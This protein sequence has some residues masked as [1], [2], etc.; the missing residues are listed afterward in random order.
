MDVQIPK[1]N[2]KRIVVVGGGFG[3]LT[4]INKLDS[5]YFQ[6][7]LVD[8]NNY[9]QF[10]PL[11]YQVASSGLE[12]G[13]ISFPFR[14]HFHKKKN[15]Y[16]RLADVKE[17]DSK[18]NQIK[19]SIGNI[20]YDYLVLA[21]GTTTN[22]FG[23]KEIEEQALPMKTVEEALELKNTLLTNL[24]KALDCSDVE[25]RK[26][27]LN[28][29]I[30]GAGATGVEIAGAL[31]EMRRYIIPKDYPD[32]KKNNLNIYLIEGSNKVLGNLS[33]ESSAN[34]LKALKKMGVNVIL[35]KRVTAYK[36]N[37]VIMDDESFIA[38][39]TLVWVSGVASQHFEGLPDEV[40][41]HAGRLLVNEYNQLQNSSNIFVLGDLCLQYE[42]SYPKGHPQVAPVAIQQGKLLASN[43][44]K[45]EKGE[46]L[47]PFKYFNQGT[48]AT[49][50]RNKAVADIK[51]LRLHGFIAWM[52][53]ML[54][55]LRSILG[56]RNKLTV[57][58]DWIWNYLTYDQSM[59]FI[60]YVKPNK[61]K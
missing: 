54:V 60:I 10:Q 18:S 22:F 33:E 26:E 52:V 7:V 59:R 19:T 11:L 31:S 56:V 23:N 28:I 1:S 14:K 34:A 30:V 13:S 43:L 53:W 3:G 45:L 27:L 48:L 9:H 38:T 21:A 50:G 17:I 15:F 61:K 20:G 8:R 42:K 36:D 39:K 35:N 16:F 29:V 41:G 32:L 51:S 25:T 58:F 5:K 24:E 2:K 40:V 44:K 12:Q 55:H 46:A 47:K 57:L 49:I 4:L 6:I 37:K